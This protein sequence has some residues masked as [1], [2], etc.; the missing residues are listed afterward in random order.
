M[1]ALETRVNLKGVFRVRLEPGWVSERAGDGA[2]LDRLRD[3]FPTVCATVF[4]PFGPFAR[5][6]SG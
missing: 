1:Q 6:F 4:R 3:R 5:P 2:I